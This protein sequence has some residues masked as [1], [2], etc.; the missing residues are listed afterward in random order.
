MTNKPMDM[1]RVRQGRMARIEREIEKTRN[2]RGE[3]GKST[4]SKLPPVGKPI[5]TAGYGVIWNY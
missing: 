4:I 5:K 1:I 3:N 2:A